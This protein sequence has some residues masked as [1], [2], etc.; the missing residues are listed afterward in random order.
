MQSMET[1]KAFLEACDTGKGWDGCRGYCTPDATFSAQADVLSEVKTLEQY[2]DWMRSLLT[3]L[4]DGSYELKAM[5]P[6]NT[7]SRI[8][9]FATFSGT[10][11][12]GGPCPPTGRR[13]RTDYVYV[14]EMR[15]DKVAHLTKVWNSGF[16]L[17]ELGWA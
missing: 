6:D 7:R 10:H 5:A 15:G 2:T 1:A 11:L 12:A 14:M 9:A 17:K 3:V 4:T 16:A 8:C 13:T